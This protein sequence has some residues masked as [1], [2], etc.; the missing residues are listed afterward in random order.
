MWTDSSLTWDSHAYS[1]RKGKKKRDANS[2][3]KEDRH[4]PL[5]GNRCWRPREPEE[6]PA[7][8]WQHLR[9]GFTLSSDSGAS[10]A[11]ECS[12]GGMDP[13]ELGRHSNCGSPMLP[14]HLGLPLTLQG[15]R[16]ARGGG[17][18]VCSGSSHDPWGLYLLVCGVRNKKLRW[19]WEDWMGEEVLE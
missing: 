4:A 14:S 18:G 12:S 10:K 8:A 16:P 1:L 11:E 9:P 3:G 5:G 19:R 6:V 7:H 13:H 17:G 15:L 2:Q